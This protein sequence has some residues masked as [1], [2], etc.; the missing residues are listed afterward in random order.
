MCILTAFLSLSFSVIDFECLK[1][2]G[3]PGGRHSADPTID[4][5]DFPTV[6]LN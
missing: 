3:Y 1:V 5:S 2:L 4:P 6:V